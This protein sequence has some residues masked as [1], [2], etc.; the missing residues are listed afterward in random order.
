MHSGHI[1]TSEVFFV[2]FLC[3]SRCT[4]RLLHTRTLARSDR[5]LATEI[6]SEAPLTKII[7]EKYEAEVLTT[8]NTN[9]PGVCDSV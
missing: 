5:R 2:S 6:R 8:V 4:S 3:V 9:N 1:W 7:R